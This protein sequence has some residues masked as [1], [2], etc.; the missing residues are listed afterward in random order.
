MVLTTA[1]PLG[2]KQP[3]LALMFQAAAVLCFIIAIIFLF[4]KIVTGEDYKKKK[5]QQ[6]ED[7]K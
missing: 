3:F 2:G 6:V 5:V 4:K 7:A 1:G